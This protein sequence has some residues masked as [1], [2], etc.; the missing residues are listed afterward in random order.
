M[1]NIDRRDFLIAG[2]AL[3]VSLAVPSIR[4]GLSPAMTAAMRDIERTMG[5]LKIAQADK[6]RDWVR[7]ET[8]GLLEGE[9]FWDWYMQ[10]DSTRTYYAAWKQ[11]Q[12]LVE[13]SLMIPAET[14]DDE[15][16]LIRALDIYAQI[17]PS[18]FATQTA[19]DLFTPRRHQAYSHDAGRVWLLTEPDDMFEK[20][21][22]P[23]FLK[24]MRQA[25]RT[26][27]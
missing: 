8:A 9:G 3:G 17:S 2:A 7:Y 12:D 23:D 5:L 21:P 14:A 18:S 24:K 26:T 1:I 6:A 11:A 10:Q 25:Q 13:Q 22:M 16:A 15:D 27:I 20:L 19:R 4:V